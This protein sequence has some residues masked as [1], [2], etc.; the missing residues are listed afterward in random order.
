MGWGQ[1]QVPIFNLAS[2]DWEFRALIPYARKS[3]P[4]FPKHSKILGKV[5]FCFSCLPQEMQRIEA[6][7][8]RVHITCKGNLAGGM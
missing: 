4:Y 7:V 3:L 8:A 6:K 5:E 1:I 2:P